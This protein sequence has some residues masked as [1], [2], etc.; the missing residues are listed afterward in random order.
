MIEAEAR[1]LRHEGDSVHAASRHEGRAFLRRPIDVARDHLPM[2]M[3]EFGHVGVVVDV[4]Y[5][6]LSFLEADERPWKL[7]VIER[8]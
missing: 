5:R 4:D 1:R 8:G 2:P 7:A 3:H 6:A